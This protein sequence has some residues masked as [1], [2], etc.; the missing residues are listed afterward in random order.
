MEK[1]RPQL[2]RPEGSVLTQSI[3]A[4]LSNGERILDDAMQLEIQEPPS[5]R[6]MLSIIAQEEFA[7]AFLLFLVR[8]AV[9]PWS[10]E[11]LRAMN[12]HTCKQLVG[13][14]IDYLNPEWKTL[15]DLR[16]LVDAD[17]ELG[18]RLPSRVASAVNILRHEKIGRWEANNW[19]WVDDADY[20]PSVLRISKGRRD[21]VKQDALYVRL[22]RDGR[23]TN[24]PSRTTQERAKEEF[25]RADSYRWFVRS[26]LRD[27]TPASI[28]YEKL[29]DTLR[30]LFGVDDKPSSAASV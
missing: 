16:K 23:V 19:F 22:G 15:D 1:D 18:D 13:I 30:A 2:P 17:F 12:D 6:L 21:R 10:G 26:L 8:E 28:S 5:T 29:R 7:K 9:I 11:L 24:T 27:G 4:C 25:A 3:E 20:E 14:I